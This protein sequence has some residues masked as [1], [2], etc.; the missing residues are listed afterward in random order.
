MGLINAGPIKSE[1]VFLKLKV[2]FKHQLHD[3][4]LETFFTF[5][6]NMWNSASYPSEL[7]KTGKKITDVE[8]YDE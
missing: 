1:I 4:A 8:N 3:S 2:L 7:D 6:G 5:V